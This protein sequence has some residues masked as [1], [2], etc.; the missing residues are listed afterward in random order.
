[1]QIF[2]RCASGAARGGW[3]WQLGRQRGSTASGL[4]DLHQRPP[5]AAGQGA[6]L[7]LSV[8]SAGA[9]P[10]IA[11]Q[12]VG[13]YVHQVQ[14]CRGDRSTDGEGETQRE[15]PSSPEPLSCTRLGS[16]CGTAG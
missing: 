1:M 11:L 16:R 12:A 14:P 10:S 9:S 3:S 7:Q 4:Q 13:Q 2:G 5:A 6:G 8:L 15:A